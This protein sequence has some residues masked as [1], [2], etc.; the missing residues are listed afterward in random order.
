MQ[1]QTISASS[2]NNNN[3]NTSHRSLLKPISLLTGMAMLTCSPRV[4]AQQAVAAPPNAAAAV[5][6]DAAQGKLSLRYH[7]TVILDA[8]VRAEDAAGQTVAG[9]AVKLAPAET[10]DPKEKV[11]QRLKFTLAEPKDG[12]KL[13]LRGTVTGSVESF[14]AETDG[15]EKTGWANPQETATVRI[16]PTATKTVEWKLQFTQ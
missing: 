11:E 12:V 5:V 7:G 8:T 6:W 9:A 16:V 3:M 2:N 4:I 10:R 1:L 13:V 14:P 15:G